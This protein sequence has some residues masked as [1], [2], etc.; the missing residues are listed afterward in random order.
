MMLWL[1]RG[2]E[3]AE[4]GVDQPPHQPPEVWLSRGLEQAETYNCPICKMEEPIA[5]PETTTRWLIL[6]N[7]WEIPSLQVN[8]LVDME[9]IVGGQVRNL[10]RAWRVDLLP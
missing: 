4:G 3:Q 7:K 9:A 1:A 6:Y 2:H 5:L 8:K 10:A